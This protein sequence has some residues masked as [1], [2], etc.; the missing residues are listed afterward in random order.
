MSKLEVLQAIGLTW[1]Y[2]MNELE[3]I[4]RGGRCKINRSSGS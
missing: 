1:R 3:R 2:N 4:A